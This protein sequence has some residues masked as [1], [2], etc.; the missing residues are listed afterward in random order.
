MIAVAGVQLGFVV[1]VDAPAIVIALISLIASVGWRIHSGWL[2][3]WAA[4]AGV[5]VHAL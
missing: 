3:A 1:L 4:A 2:I 5:I